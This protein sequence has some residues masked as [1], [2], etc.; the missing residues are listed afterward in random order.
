V[1]RTGA[2]LARIVH[3]ERFGFDGAAQESNLPSP[4]LHDLTGFW[5]AYGSC[6]GLVG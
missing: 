5:E 1:A 3:I 2:Q 6:P 4:G